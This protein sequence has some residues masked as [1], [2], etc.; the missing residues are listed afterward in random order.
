ML[1][2]GLL[3]SAEV[4]EDHTIGMIIFLCISSLILEWWQLT[5]E[6]TGQM[7]D[8]SWKMIQHLRGSI[9]ENLKKNK[10]SH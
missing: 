9:Q 5:L 8:A 4:V 10:K 7:K 3:A 2:S 1:I 6:E